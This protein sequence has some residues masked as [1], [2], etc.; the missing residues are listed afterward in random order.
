[1]FALCEEAV[2]TIRLPLGVALATVR[3]PDTATTPAV[4]SEYASHTTVFLLL[5]V[6]SQ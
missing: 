3:A 5:I 4:K 1:M 6:F 2:F